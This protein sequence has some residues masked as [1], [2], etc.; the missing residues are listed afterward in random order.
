MSR[1]VYFIIRMFTWLL[2]YLLLPRYT[3][4]LFYSIVPSIR[5]WENTSITY[6]IEVEKTI[7]SKLNQKMSN[8]KHRSLSSWREKKWRKT[9]ELIQANLYTM[10]YNIHNE[11]N[12]KQSRSSFETSFSKMS[13]IFLKSTPDLLDVDPPRTNDQAYLSSFFQNWIFAIQQIY[14]YSS[15]IMWFCASMDLLLTFIITISGRIEVLPP[16]DIRFMSIDSW[17]RFW[18][19]NFLNRIVD[20]KEYILSRVLIK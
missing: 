18:F 4:R 17:I 2:A 3:V 6:L 19:N 16:I 10:A 9:F 13:P 7:K 5:T 8:Q 15:K 14:Y 12:S 20:R 1:C 11:N